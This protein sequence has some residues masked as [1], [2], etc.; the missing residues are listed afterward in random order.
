MTAQVNK[1]AV[2]P[3]DEQ[4]EKLNKRGELEAEVGAL[5]KELA[6]L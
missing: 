5:E 3:S 4:M 2:T 6:A 1:G